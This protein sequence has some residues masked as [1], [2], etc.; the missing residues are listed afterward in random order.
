MK[1]YGQ[2]KIRYT[3]VR[4]F[5]QRRGHQYKIVFYLIDKEKPLATFK[6]C[7]CNLLE[8]IESIKKNLNKVIENKELN[9]GLKKEHVGYIG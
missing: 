6:I 3:I 8:L 1:D 2:P 9:T 7:E 5:S 4:D